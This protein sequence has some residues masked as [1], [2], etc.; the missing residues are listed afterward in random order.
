MKERRKREVDEEEQFH[1]MLGLDRGYHF[2][3]STC[4]AL[5]PETYGAPRSAS[6]P[7]AVP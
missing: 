4:L 2:M 7:A 5:L 6:N 1:E 3:V